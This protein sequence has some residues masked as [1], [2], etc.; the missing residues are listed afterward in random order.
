MS[1]GSADLMSASTRTVAWGIAVVLLG[2]LGGVSVA[3]QQPVV[4]D[5]P[6]TEISGSAGAAATDESTAK[7]FVRDVGSDYKNF[8]SVETAIWLGGRRRG[9]CRSD[10]GRPAIS[11]A[12]RDANNL[13]PG[14]AG[15]RSSAVSASAFAIGWWAI[16]SAAG[17]ARHAED[18][19][20]SPA[21]QI[22]G[23]QL[24]LRDQ[25]GDRSD[26]S[27]RRFVSTSLGARVHL[28]RHGNGAGG[29]LWS[30]VGRRLR[31]SSPAIPPRLASSQR[32]HWTSDGGLGAAS[33]SR[34]LLAL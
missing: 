29:S 27:Q 15:L 1:E 22:A 26:A 34:R 14:G 31:F 30:G 25:A 6:A 18:W 32:D 11:D 19:P 21:M 17:S 28:V 7:R 10:P 4:T 24:D 23:V 33:C 9:A 3:A 5:E 20:R 16:A 13:P 8:F 2:S 12:A